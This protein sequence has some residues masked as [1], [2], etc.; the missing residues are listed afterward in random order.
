M[1][2][3]PTNRNLGMTL[4][5]HPCSWTKTV[6]H[7]QAHRRNTVW[8]SCP[9]ATN[10]STI[11]QSLSFLLPV[12]GAAWSSSCLCPAPLDASTWTIPLAAGVSQVCLVR[13]VLSIQSQALTLSS[14]D[15]S[16]IGTCQDP[17]SD[18]YGEDT[19]SNN[20]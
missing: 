8:F 10:G 20:R 12:T 18:S 7:N 5:L 9:Q 6:G 11:N 4:T 17:V 16:S 1:P 2:V 19:I 3:G 14:P 15:F 13:S